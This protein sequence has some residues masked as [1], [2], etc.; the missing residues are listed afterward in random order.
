MANVDDQLTDKP[1]NQPQQ[2][3]MAYRKRNQQGISVLGVL[4]VILLML[5]VIWTAF[6]LTKQ[7]LTPKPPTI[8][9]QGIISQM[10]TLSRLQTATFAIDTVVTAKQDGSWQKLW[11]D[12]QKGLFIIKGRVLAG[13]DLQQITPE[14]VQIH[15]ETD[16]TLPSVRV[17]LPP[18]QIFEVFLDHIE[19]YDWQTGVFGAKTV[20]ARLF[21]QVQKD[22]KAEILQKACQGDVINL[23][24]TQAVQQLQLLFSKLPMQVQIQS[25][26]A[27]RCQFANL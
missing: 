23:A 18:S 26:G 11:Q 6:T 3:M 10:T 14:M 17:Q 21:A 22:A 27:G 19:I 20:D 24:N 13:V 5:V 25:Q 9:A 12:E 1:H 2:T 7:Q 8:D 16:G 4:A 15:Q